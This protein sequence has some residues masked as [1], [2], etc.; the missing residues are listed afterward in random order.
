[1]IMTSRATAAPVPVPGLPLPARSANT[2]SQRLAARPKPHVGVE[3]GSIAAALRWLLD[4]RGFV[5]R[6]IAARHQCRS[7]GDSTE[8]SII[9]NIVTERW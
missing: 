5:E 3:Y 2:E 1:V 9:A 7:W 8:R 6:A 4:R